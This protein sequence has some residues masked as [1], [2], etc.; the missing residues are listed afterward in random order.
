VE[1]RRKKKEKRKKREKRKKKGIVEDMRFFF[2]FQ[3][4]KT[5]ETQEGI[6]NLKMKR[7]QTHSIYF[8]FIV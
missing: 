4:Q 6:E 8:V 3:A 5:K 2:F 1:L 7:Y